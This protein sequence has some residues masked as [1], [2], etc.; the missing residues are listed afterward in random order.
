MKV[1][2]SRRRIFE[3]LAALL[4]GNLADALPDKSDE[5]SWQT[6][7]TLADLHKSVPPLAFCLR[8]SD[9]R[10]RI[11]QD[12]SAV[13][14]AVYELN[15]DRD[16]ALADQG[17]GILS[18]LNEAG[19]HAV[20][21]KG[22]AYKA[23]GLHDAFG[24]RLTGD[25]DILVPRNSLKA[26]YELIIREGYVPRTDEPF[27]EAFEHHP[28]LLKPPPD[29][30][31]LA[32]IDVH[33]RLGRRRHLSLLP[34]GEILENARTVTIDDQSVRVPQ[35]LDLLQHAVVH[36]GLQNRL[37]RRRTT[38][39]RD[40]L[41][42]GRLWALVSREGCQI[43]DLPI[44]RH[45]QA[46]PYF[47]ACL[48]LFGHQPSDL[49]ALADASQRCYAQILARQ[50]IA[51]RPGLEM[52]IAAH[53]EALIERPLYVASKFAKPAFYAKILDRIRSRTV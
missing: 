31:L 22:L 21:V 17:F 14:D 53:L 39:F 25:I 26:A 15:L 47:G 10:D 38:R 11:P 36:S 45:H 29:S 37:L 49:G 42:I 32:S 23:I 18:R 19:L 4:R 6:L 2:S 12:V 27:D 50:V 44:A 1:W 30:D 13:L 24:G 5:A 3:H 41:D 48:L 16:A 40:V 33:I 7:V 51:E 34:P 46:G 8:N 9:V 28:P 52:S 43:S 35:P 20:A